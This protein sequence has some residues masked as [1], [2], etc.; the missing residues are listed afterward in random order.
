MKREDLDERS[1]QLAFRDLRVAMHKNLIKKGLGKLASP[2][3]ALG[4]IAEEQKELV[5]AI[6]ANDAAWIR[7]EL[8]D[9]AV[10][11][12]FAVACDTPKYR[13]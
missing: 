9:L 11:A 6:Q 8:M 5:D 2:H 12:L 13:S 3:E 1:L 4:M 10:A 7:R